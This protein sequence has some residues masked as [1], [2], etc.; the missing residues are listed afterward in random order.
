NV[1]G[2]TVPNG[3]PASFSGTLGT[4]SPANTT[5]S[6]SAA[7]STFTAGSSGGT[8]TVIATVDKQSLTNTI[9][10]NQPPLI[11]SAT[12]TTFT[13]GINGSFQVTKTGVP[14][15]GLSQSGALPGAVGFNSGTGVLS[16][17]PAAGTGGTYPITFTATN[18]AGTN[19]QNFTL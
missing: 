14:T 8:A 16:G 1:S 12:N 4:V 3:T 18:S 19:A 15:P 2:F 7:T 13:V 9:T 5:M 6:S 10:I 11:T 17:I